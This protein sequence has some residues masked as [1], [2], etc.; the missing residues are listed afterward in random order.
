MKDFFL[1]TGARERVRLPQGDLVPR[2][3]TII[4]NTAYVAN[5]FSDTL[6]AIDLKTPH[7]E[8]ESIS[9]GPTPKMSAARKGEF[10]FQRCDHLFGGMAELCKLPSR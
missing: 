10:L 8:I 6:S 7:G 2:A 4:G 5:Y 9:L 1:L 3:V